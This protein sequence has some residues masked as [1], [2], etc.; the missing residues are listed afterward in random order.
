MTTIFN[1]T[2]LALIFGRTDI[3]IP[4]EYGTAPKFNELFFGPLSSF[5]ENFNSVANF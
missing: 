3:K 4:L 2:N 1:M 5:T